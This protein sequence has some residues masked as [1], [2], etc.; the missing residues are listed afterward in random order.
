MK[1]LITTLTAML[2]VFSMTAQ[3]RQMSVTLKKP[4]TLAACIGDKNIKSVEKLTIK[5]QL[6]TADVILLRQMAG[7]DVAGKETEGGRLSILNLRNASFAPDTACFVRT[8]K[9]KKNLGEGGVDLP[10]RIFSGCRLREFIFPKG[11]LHI[12]EYAL[13]HTRLSTIA[14]PENVVLERFAFWDCKELTQVIF[15]KVLKEMWGGTFLGCNKLER[16]DINNVEVLYGYSFYQMN[17]LRQVN[18]NGWCIYADGF[19]IADCPELETVDFRG[20]VLTTGGELVAARCPKLET[21]TFHAPVYHTFFGATDSCAVFKGFVAKDV[22][23]KS[24]NKKA[25]PVTPIDTI[26]ARYES[27]SASLA[28][29]KADYQDQYKWTEMASESLNAPVY[30]AACRYSLDNDKERATDLFEKVVANGFRKY[31]HFLEDTDLDNIRQEPRFQAVMADLKTTEG[32]IVKLKASAPYTS[33][34]RRANITFT[35]QSLSD[36][37]LTAIRQYFNLD[38]IAGSGDEISR[39]KRIMYWLHDA[40]PHDGSSSWPKCR[41]NAIELYELCKREDRGLNCRFMSEV[42]NDLYLAAGFKSR[43][44][45]CQSKEYDTDSDCHVINMV[46]SNEL[47]KWVWMD[48][49]FAAYVTDENG[50]LLHPGEVRERLRKDQPVILNEDANWNHQRAETKEHYIDYYMAKNLYLLCAHERSKSE[51]ESW[52]DTDESPM[53]IL[54]PQGFQYKVDETKIV[55]EDDSEFFCPPD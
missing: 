39:M 55:T 22:V 8:P 36:S 1:R 12:G 19:L 41:Y 4:G 24:N 45:T 27:L 53:V 51:S 50:L 40:I 20:E 31:Y 42:L 47:G 54:A 26:L 3:K 29:F 44:L 34:G 2:M 11:T 38:S 6:N 35:Y 25:V 16:I 48:A 9:Y 49:S 15:P 30:D 10:D 33:N 17:S 5:G 46:W 21:L 7:R 23:I 43:F 32:K 37:L 13:S 14:L 18:V 52:N 28:R